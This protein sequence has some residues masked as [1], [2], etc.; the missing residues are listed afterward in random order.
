MTPALGKAPAVPAVTLEVGRLLRGAGALAG[1]LSVLGILLL[2]PAGTHPWAVTQPS[3]TGCGSR[4]PNPPPVAA[5]AMARC[6][7][8]VGREGSASGTPLEPLW[9][10]RTQRGSLPSAGVCRGSGS[11]AKGSPFRN[12]A[13]PKAS[14]ARPGT[15]LGAGSPTLQPHLE[16]GRAGAAP[17]RS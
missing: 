11:T 8:H 4:K 7:L 2:P 16:P 9:D 3:P 6:P 15:A 1:P 14:P 17:S 5:H 12:G 13:V 10:P